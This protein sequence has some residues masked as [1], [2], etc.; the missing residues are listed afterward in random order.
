MVLQ[1]TTIHH[2]NTTCTEK[3]NKQT[4]VFGKTTARVISTSC[5][6]YM[7]KKT[8]KYFDN[9]PTFSLEVQK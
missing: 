6:F 7:A 5:T 2:K 9:C 1:F 3:T 4:Y 8:I